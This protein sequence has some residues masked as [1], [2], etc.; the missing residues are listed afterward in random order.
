MQKLSTLRL[1]QDGGERKEKKKGG[2]K[3][4]GE[5]AGLFFCFFVLAFVTSH[6]SVTFPITI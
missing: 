2:N 6:F 1:S 4:K 5:I 3:A